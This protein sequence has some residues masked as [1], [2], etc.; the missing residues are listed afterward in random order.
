M[1][2]FGEIHQLNSH[3]PLKVHFKF[4]AML[5]EIIYFHNIFSIEFL[6]VAPV[7]KGWKEKENQVF[8][9]DSRDV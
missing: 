7:S 2:T 6:F 9:G 3:I 8:P 4:S 5:W 1:G